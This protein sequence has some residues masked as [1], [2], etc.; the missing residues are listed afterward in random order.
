[1]SVHFLICELAR[2]PFRHAYSYLENIL[3]YP[4]IIQ[5]HVGCCQQT[6]N[7]IW[8]WLD[9]YP[10]SAVEKESYQGELFERAALAVDVGPAIWRTSRWSMKGTVRPGK[11]NFQPFSTM[12]SSETNVVQNDTLERT[13]VKSSL[14]RSAAICLICDTSWLIGTDTLINARE[15]KESLLMFKISSSGFYFVNLKLG[16]ARIGKLATHFLVWPQ[17]LLFTVWSGANHF[18]LDWLFY[19]LLA[20]STVGDYW[21][22]NVFHL[23]VR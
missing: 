16:E 20:Q 2:L 15:R 3:I 9:C 21:N 18:S 10:D 5:A 1:M 4:Q 11:A 14:K 7:S 13:Q 6:R 8:Y 17:R 19:T 22:I 23:K 12:Q